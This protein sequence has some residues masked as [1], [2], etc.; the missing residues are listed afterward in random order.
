MLKV[1]HQ[2]FA[3][4][5]QFQQRFSQEAQTAAGRSHPSIVDIYYFGATQGLLYTVMAFVP[6]SSLAAHIRRMQK[7]GEVVQL[8]ETLALLAQVADAV[9]Y[10]HRQGVVHRDIEPSNVAATTIEPARPGGRPTLTGHRDRLWAGKTARRGHPDA[11]G[12]VYGVIPLH[13]SG[14]ETKRLRRDGD[15]NYWQRKE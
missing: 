1:M 10:A 2:Q 7:T 4:Q 14:V 15:C 6:G 9:G 13:V 3:R 8:R 12:G 11:V 5:P